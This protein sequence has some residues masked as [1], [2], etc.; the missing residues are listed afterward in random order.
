MRRGRTF[1]S[2]HRNWEDEEEG[3][4]MRKMRRRTF[5]SFCRDR[6]DEEEGEAGVVRLLSPKGA[7]ELSELTDCASP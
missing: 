5:L 7:S 2:F 4:M 1:L 3:E 6:K